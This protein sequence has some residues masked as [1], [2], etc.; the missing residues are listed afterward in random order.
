[1]P[2]VEFDRAI[3]ER[4]AGLF[5]ALTRDGAMIPA[6]DLA[7][8]ATATHL[9]FAVLLGPEGGSTASVCPTSV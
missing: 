4:W 3:A 1:M 6:N 7:V 8:A 9:G 2:I 5:A